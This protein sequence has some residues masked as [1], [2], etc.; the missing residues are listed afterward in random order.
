MDMHNDVL[1]LIRFL[2]TPVSRIG[3]VRFTYVS[4]FSVRRSSSTIERLFS[5]VT[6]KFSSIVAHSSA[7]VGVVDERQPVKTR[8]ICI[9]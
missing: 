7:D 2:L 5:V 4:D 1:K 8:K 9:R 6:E 3:L